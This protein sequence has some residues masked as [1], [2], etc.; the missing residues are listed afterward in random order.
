M[1]YAADL[2]ALKK[3]SGNEVEFVYS[4][5]LKRYV[6]SAKQK[7]TFAENQIREPFKLEERSPLYERPQNFD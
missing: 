1:C 2:P 7:T 3:I 5:E 4:S 6:L